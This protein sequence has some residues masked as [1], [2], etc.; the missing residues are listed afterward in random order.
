[1]ITGIDDTS[2]MRR[3]LFIFFVVFWLGACTDSPLAIATATPTP[4]PTFTPTPTPD[5]TGVWL[6]LLAGIQVVQMQDGIVALRH[7]PGAVS[8]QASFQPDP[9]QVK[10]VGDWLAQT[11]GALAA[12]NCGFYLEKEGMYQ[13]IGLLMAKGYLWQKLRPNWGSVLIVRDGV[14]FVARR[15][16]QLLAPAELG[17][18]GWP[19]LVWRGVS[20]S[21]LDNTNVAR[22]TAVGTDARGR[23]VWVAAPVPL[24]LADFAQRLLMPDLGLIDAVNLD[25]GASTALRWSDPQTQHGP[26][27]LPTPC[28]IL[29]SPP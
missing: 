27:N 1:M 7:R 28:V 22:R 24:T 12:S 23:L 19:T 26:N 15:P 9:N 3:F 13:H 17:I 11:P 16:K 29:L 6:P 4:A 18:Q 10:T 2:C 21:G 20:V 25:G 14:G 5:T 8:Y